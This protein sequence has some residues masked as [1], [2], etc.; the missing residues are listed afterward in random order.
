MEKMSCES[1]NVETEAY[2]TSIRF[3]IKGIKNPDI[4]KRLS[5]IVQNIWQ[6]EK[7]HEN[8]HD[9]SGGQDLA[10]AEK[11][12]IHDKK[13]VRSFSGKETNHDIKAV[14]LSER[15]QSF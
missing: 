2:R 7:R 1:K 15:W 5:C 14:S 9:K 13:M 6:D 12:S 4:L 11:V 10:K 3:C 8:I